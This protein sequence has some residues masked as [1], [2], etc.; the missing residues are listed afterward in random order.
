MSLAPPATVRFWPSMN[1]SSKAAVPLGVVLR[2]GSPPLKAGSRPLPTSTGDCTS[3]CMPRGLGGQPLQFLVAVKLP[4]VT[5]VPVTAVPSS[6]TAGFALEIWDPDAVN[7]A[8]PL[9]LLK[10]DPENTI[11]DRR[12]LRCS[13]YADDFSKVSV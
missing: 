5:G 9:A 10:L 8:V 13:R 7:P 3:T 11:V 6:A 4:D 2:T 12:V 1:R